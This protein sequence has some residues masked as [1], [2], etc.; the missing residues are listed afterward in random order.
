MKIG[1]ICDGHADCSLEPGCFLREDPVTWSDT[2]CRHTWDP[3]HAVNG[4]CLHPENHPERFT[5]FPEF[6]RVDYYERLPMEE[7]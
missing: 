3:Q 7:L 2:V 5:G 4:I 6:E 1:Y